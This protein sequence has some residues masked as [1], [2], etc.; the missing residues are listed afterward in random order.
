MK[1]KKDIVLLFY[2]L[3]GIMVGSLIASA[4]AGIPALSWL[5]YGQ[6]IGIPTSNPMYLDLAVVQVA[7]ALEMGVN[8]AQII[9][10]ILSLFFYRWT[11]KRI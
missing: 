1:L 7:F 11:I 5:S 10:I 2:I 4:T 6:S 9:C 3:A 8:I